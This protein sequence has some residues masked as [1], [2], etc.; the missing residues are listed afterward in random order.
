MT[1]VAT[2]G[3]TLKSD[4]GLGVSVRYSSET[5]DAIEGF[6]PCDVYS[7][8]CPDCVPKYR[9]WYPDLEVIP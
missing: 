3:H 1:I 7:Q 9:E 2:C 5:C 6:I 8:L 4:E